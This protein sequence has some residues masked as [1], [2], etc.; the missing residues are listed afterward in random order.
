MSAAFIVE[1]VIMQWFAELFPK[2]GECK[3]GIS[4]WGENYIK[5]SGWRKKW[6]YEVFSSSMLFGELHLSFG[7]CF[8][9]LL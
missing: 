2:K 6:E 9:T 1:N 8:L 5:L 7:G 3:I 4:F